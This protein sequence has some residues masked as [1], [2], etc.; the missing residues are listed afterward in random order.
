LRYAFA[1][2]FCPAIGAAGVTYDFS[3]QEIDQLNMASTAAGVSAPAP[4]VTRYFVD[5][6]RVRIGAA[7]AKT[8][9]LYEDQTVYAIDDA[10]RSIRVLKHATLS[11]IAAH[12]ADA[13][14]RLEQAAEAAPPQ[15][16][17]EAQRKASDLKA[18]S[19]RLQKPVPREYAMTVRF[20]SVDGHACRI[21]EER[22]GEVKRLELCVA[23]TAALPGGDELLNGLNLLGAFREGG[24]RALGVDFGLSDWRPDLLHLGGVPLLIREFRYGSLVREVTLTSIRA[25][26]PAASLWALPEGYR[27]QE[28]PGYSG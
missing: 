25:G 1:L 9:Y 16:R 23:P 13:V 20:E 14:S 4:L 15:D 5:H 19:E 18:A 27:L 10:S 3:V 11:Q 28:D 8:V 12:Y 7:G 26:E 6:G 17:A 24:T 21:W 2:L 22:E